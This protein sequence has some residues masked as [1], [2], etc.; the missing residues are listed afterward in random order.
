[1]NLRC[2]ISPFDESLVSSLLSSRSAPLRPATHSSRSFSRLSSNNRAMLTRGM[3]LPLGYELMHRRRSGAGQQPFAERLVAEHLGKFREY[4]Q[5]QVGGAV[6]H[7]QHEDE[8]DRLA[9]GRVER[10]RLLHPHERADRLL[11]PLDPAVRDRDPLAEAGGAELFPREQAVE[12]LAACDLVMVLEQ[13]PDLL[14][15]ALLA[16]RVELQDDV[17]RRQQ[18]ADQVHVRRSWFGPRPPPAPGL[19]LA[20][21]LDGAAMAVLE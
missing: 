8:A 18:L 17:R 12:H 19:A 14:E 11:Q 3:R 9:V 6:G 2:P 16:A 4:L 5:V 15:D 20:L 7:Q 1:M 10:D 21:V 13:Q